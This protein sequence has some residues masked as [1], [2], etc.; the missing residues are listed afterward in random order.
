M[1]CAEVTLLNLLEYYSNSY[2][3]YRIIVPSEIIENEQKHSHERVLPVRGIT[4]PVLTKVLSEFGFSPRLYNI[5]AIDS[6]N[7]RLQ[8]ERMNLNVG[9]IIILNQQFQLQSILFQ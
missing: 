3:D 5:S 8:A 1:C 7:T 2:N 4:Y 6:L 9:C